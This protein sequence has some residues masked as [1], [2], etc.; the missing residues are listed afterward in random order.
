MDLDDPFGEVGWCGDDE[1][2]AIGDLA[3]GLPWD[4]PPSDGDVLQAM[5][6]DEGPVDHH[7]NVAFI[8]AR[9]FDGRK[10]GYVFHVGDFGVGYYLDTWAV[11]QRPA[12]RHQHGG[13][14][15]P[16]PPHGSHRVHG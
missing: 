8:A 11:P 5:H 2:D 6:V 15:R 10:E 16:C 14:P 9:H 7:G 4:L 3:V 1:D 12:D 13:R